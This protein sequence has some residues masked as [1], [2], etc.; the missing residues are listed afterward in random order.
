VRHRRH[1]IWPVLALAAVLDLLGLS[2][3]GVQ[4]VYYEAAV[5]SMAHGWN[6]FLFASLDPGSFITVDKPPLAFYP[7]AVLA[8]VLGL[9]RWTIGLPQVLES[10]ATVFVLWRI[11]ARRFGEAAGL[12][13]ASTL[14]VTPIVVAASHDDIPDPLLA[15]LLVSAAWAVLRGAEDGRLRW[16]LLVG[17][18]V[19]LGFQTKTIAAFLVVPGLALGYWIAAR[20]S[21]RRRLACL[22]AG[23][24]ASI[25][26]SLPWVLMVA[27]TPASDRPWVG[28]T[29]EN[30][31]LALAVSRT[32]FDQFSPIGRD[33]F[34]P[35]GFGG[36]PRLTRLFNGELAGQGAWFLLAAFGGALLALWSAWRA[37]D[38]ERLGAVALFALWALVHAGIFSY[39]TGIFHAYYLLALAPALA[40]LVGTG[41]VAAAEAARAGRGG[42]LAVAFAVVVAALGELKVLARTPDYLSWLRPLVIAL[43]AVA[44][45][46]LVMRRLRSVALV[47]ALVALAV[48]PAAWAIGAS[49]EHQIGPLPMAGPKRPDA[50]TSYLAPGLPDLARF[51]RAHRHG[52]RWDVAT[53]DAIGAAPLILEGVR[54]AALGGF[55]GVDPAGTRMSIRKLIAEGKLRYVLTFDPAFGYFDGET[56][57]LR[58]VTAVRTTCPLARTTPAAEPTFPDWRSALYDCK[59]RRLS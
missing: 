35:L 30:T 57:A 46:P 56:E 59:G 26:C 36:E 27:L 1:L 43:A 52:E 42:R 16:L 11:V 23:G 47:A 20:T 37:R 6:A 10:V 55:L 4:T 7:E 38:R 18:F 2:R 58:V 54:A 45:V 41:A 44:V 51:L 9:N 17:L 48:A 5:K 50:A 31:A 33:G 21:C 8:H 39:A 22:A 49:R 13:A 12:I 19:G 40:G 14:A 15:L 3:S 24:A 28:G 32:G 29:T 53:T 34:R 25:V